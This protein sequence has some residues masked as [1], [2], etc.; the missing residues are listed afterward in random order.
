LNPSCVNKPRLSI[1]AMLTSRPE[2]LTPAGLFVIAMISISFFALYYIQ[3]ISLS[4]VTGYDVEQNIFFGADHLEPVWGWVCCHKGVHPLLLLFVVP[5]TKF[6]HIF[7]PSTLNCVLI[8]NSLFGCLGTLL[9]FFFFRELTHQPVQSV[10][11]TILFGFSAS[12][13]IF[14]SVP[15]SYSLSAC[16]IVITYILFLSSLQNKKIN[17]K[18]WIMAGTLTLGV[19]VTNFIQTFICFTVALFAV[20][21][22]RNKLY[23]LMR[24]V[25]AVFSIVFIFNRVQ[26]IIFGGQLFIDPQVYL[27]E[28]QYLK[29]LLFNHPIFVL[30]EIMKNF[31]LINIIASFPGVSRMTSNIPALS[32]YGVPL[33]FT[34]FGLL[35][36]MIWI[37]LIFRKLFEKRRMQY[38]GFYLIGISL[39]I[40]ANILIHIFFN[41]DELFLY[42]CNF[43][44]PVLLL[45]LPF[46]RQ[47]SKIINLLLVLLV[48]LM[49]INNLIILRN[50]SFL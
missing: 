32:F 2:P 35:G 33:Q 10:L 26:Y 29:P 24:Y 37:I 13:L 27:Y 8:I 7:I 30:K 44:F 45:L 6:L 48:I 43:S 17:T 50:I 20:E 36:I 28:T 39:S 38:E 40:L 34:F 22:E 9:A 18:L 15:E 25:I 42:T 46:N 21:K 3:G 47:N 4:Q 16:S 5:I 14:S 23:A 12:Q 31:F 11:L 1:N 49:G 19:V 41:I